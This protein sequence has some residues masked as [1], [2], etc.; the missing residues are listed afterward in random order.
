VATKTK[1]KKILE[2]NLNVPEKTK[3][4]PL[5][6]P[7]GTWWRKFWM[8]PVIIILVTAIIGLTCLAV[9]FPRVEIETVTVTE[10]VTVT[11]EK[12][13]EKI[14]YRDVEV[15]VGLPGPIINNP[16]GEIHFLSS[17]EA[18][19]EVHELGVKNIKMTFVTAKIP[20]REVAQQAVVG[21]PEN[22]SVSAWFARSP[23]TLSWV[24]VEII[25]QLSGWSEEIFPTFDSS[26]HKWCRIE[27]GTIVEVTSE[28]ISSNDFYWGMGRISIPRQ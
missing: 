28:W 16:S 10:N 17:I 24:V 9:F 19:D 14:V 4:I 25:P 2:L 20:E 13:V 12:E 5:W 21:K 11:V 23:D 3:L 7:T 26:G 27:N 18:R 22:I 1:K 8:W 6:L 15:Q